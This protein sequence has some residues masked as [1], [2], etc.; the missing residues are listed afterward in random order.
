MEGEH[1]IVLEGVTKAVR[2][3]AGAR[4]ILRNV[5]LR[6]PRG[7]L[8]GLI[9]P[10]AAGK[11]V[12]LKMIA[13]LMKPD[14]GS[15]KVDGQEVTQL[16][17]LRMAD[18]RMKIGMLFQNNALFDHMTV[19]ENVAFPLRRLY[20]LPEEEVQRRVIERLERVAL[21]GFEDRLPSG[22]SGGQKKRVG[23][24]RAGVTNA[25]LVLYDEPAAGLDPVTSQKIFDLLRAEQ[26][27][28]DATVLMV[29]SDLDRL[30]RAALPGNDRG[31]EGVPRAARPT[32][33]PRPHGGSP[34]TLSQ[35]THPSPPPRLPVQSTARTVFTDVLLTL[36]LLAQA[37]T[38]AH[39]PERPS[40]RAV[41]DAVAPSVVAITNDDRDE[42]EQEARDA[43]KSLGD[44]AKA[45][46]HV[47]DVSL[48]KEPSPHGTGFA[49]DGGLVLTAAHVVFR[50]D[51][52]KVTTRSGQTVDAELVR[53]DE[54][55]DVALLKPKTP[56]DGVP[57]LALEEHDVSVG[58]PVWAMGHT[59]R[60]Y[61]ALSWGISEGIASGVV[62]VVG[63]KLLLFDATVYPGFSGGP[64]VTFHDGV[65]RV[66]G[67]NHAILYTTAL[68]ST[69]V[70]SGVTVSELREFVADK[71]PPLEA[72][73]AEYAK[74]QRAHVGAQLF[75]TDKLSVQRT[76][77]GEPI[78]YVSGDTRSMDVR[79]E[80]RV[81]C[82]AMLFGL[83]PGP[84]TL[85]FQI[86]GPGG[87][88]LTSHDEKVDVK[89]GERV[90]FTST[91]LTFAPKQEGRHVLEVLHAGKVVGR[92][93][94]TLE[95]Q[96]VGEE[97]HDHEA[98]VASDDGD[99]TA[100]LV[101]A[102]SAHEE[103]LALSGVRSTW[104]EKSYPRRV[105]YNFFARGS[106]G[107]SGTNVVIS[108]YVLDDAGHVV[109]S[110]VGCIE[111]EL[112]P[113]HTWT[114]TGSSGRTPPLVGKSGSYD[115]VL[116]LNGRPVGWWPMEATARKG[117]PSA[118]DMDRWL[119]MMRK[120]KK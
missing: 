84:V 101:V 83:L 86:R 78:A 33:R 103:P 49:I 31:G 20:S 39:S 3:L 41:F 16:S 61:W 51:R 65:P 13:G 80:A 99:P 75:V 102:Q 19:S 96:G 70:F 93:A 88:V 45:P 60:G 5:S 82:V 79:T 94:L 47:I 9:G 95:V 92:A 81:P 59:G 29:S 24:A 55:R 4:T 71:R 64:V 11:S 7:C 27:R 22:L 52:L 28:E 14:R 38:G 69:P 72:R 116:A 117:V 53:F 66:A 18:L 62:D 17:E 97:L 110:N 119:D 12:V 57:P 74:T 100:D 54:I 68:F 26:R 32:V 6:V 48:R 76:P 56:L 108:A 37:C 43:E 115:V 109:G 21:P 2:S 10:G 25:P 8:F 73:L 40:A 1:A 44:D 35:T 114:C 91:L 98:N 106:R 46:R 30:R 36:T 112:R 113:A 85:G 120:G 87:A 118:A 104:T 105:E 67:L 58:E 63:S 42:H 77:S 34:L 107:W 23:V 111:D 50:P 89:G 15:I 90:T